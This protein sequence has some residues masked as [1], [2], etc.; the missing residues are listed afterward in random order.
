M[1][2]G[3]DA[4][5]RATEVAMD[6]IHQKFGDI[7]LRPATLVKPGKIDEASGYGTESR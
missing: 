4:R 6:K 3:S 2:W 5:G 7:S 1:A